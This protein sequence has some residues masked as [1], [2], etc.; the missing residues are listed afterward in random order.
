MENN[1]DPIH[2]DK[3]H[4]A[5]TEP[6]CVQ[7]AAQRNYSWCT[8]GLSAKQPFCDG[9]HKQVEGMP[10]K[11]LKHSFQQDEEVWYCMCKQTKT[12]PF[13]DGSHKKRARE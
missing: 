10:F 5:A 6:V 12:P 2:L 13:C 4:T 11:S 7:V 3:A 8:C 9:K 1:Q